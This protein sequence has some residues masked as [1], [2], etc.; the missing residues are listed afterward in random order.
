MK[1]HNDEIIIPGTSGI[2]SLRECPEAIP[3]A[4]EWF[5]GKWGIPVGAYLE[6]MRLSCV[7]DG[8]VP[9]WYVIFDAQRRIIAGL[10]VIENDFHKRPDLTPNLCA[11]YVE[12]PYRRRGLARALLEHACM[13][14]REQGIGDAY[15]ITSH[16]EF[17]ERC[18]WVFYGMVEENDGGMIRMYHRS[19]GGAELK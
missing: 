6:S 17:Y 3:E 2:V 16:T 9:E 14:L 11:L 8:G 12:A 15:L 10:G 13:S 1:C 4:A 5:H 7:A 19:C 18:G